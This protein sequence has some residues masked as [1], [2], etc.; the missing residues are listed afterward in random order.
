MWTKRALCVIQLFALGVAVHVILEMAPCVL[1]SNKYACRRK[2]LR[3]SYTT[4]NLKNLF[5]V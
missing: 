3:E 4:E 1:Y 5:Q 2:L